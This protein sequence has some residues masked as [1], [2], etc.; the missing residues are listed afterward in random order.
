MDGVMEG[1]H[2]DSRGQ[3]E[4]ISVV[5]LMG[6]T[7]AGMVTVVA[8]GSVALNENQRFSEVQGTDHA[9][10]QLDSRAAVV[11]LGES[12][13]QEV[14]LGRTGGSY[15][16]HEDAGRLI[17]THTNQSQQQPPDNETIYNRSLGAIVY[18][19]AETEVA[20]QGGGVWRKRGNGSTMVSPPEFHYQSAT[21][22]FPI[23]RVRGTGSQAGSVVAQITRPDDMRR[24]YP[25]TSS[26][27]DASGDTYQNPVEG[28]NVT[29]TIQSEYYRAWEN[30]FKSRT[31]G[32]V[33]V[34]H[35]NETVKVT[36]LS[37]SFIGEFE[38]PADGNS[39]DIDGLDGNDHSIENF[40]ITIY[41][42]DTDSADFAD[43]QWSLYDDQGNEEIE[44]HLQDGGSNDNG[45]TACT[46]R[47]V[48]ATVY[49]SDTNGDP[50][51]GW[52]NDTA[53]R[54]ECYDRD[55]DG[56]DDETRLVANFTGDTP[57]TTQ[58]LSSSDLLHFNPSGD[59]RE[60]PASWDQHSA[61]VSWEPE[62]FSNPEDTTIRNITG[63]YM[64]LMGP[65]VSLTVED[66][67]G[68]TVNE[69]ASGGTLEFE[70]S[71]QFVTFLHVTENDIRVKL[72]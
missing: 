3:A 41:P 22:T 1:F 4:T 15:S 14:N 25:N 26:T 59:T 28:G 72:E 61:G 20:Y 53:F 51:H 48:E 11:A 19:N 2:A 13:S 45:S 30:Y 54:T 40:T 46:E 16:I 43:L 29:V 8:L 38:M 7:V 42:D 64:A 67:S 6:I 10:T 5:L 44:F 68:G 60:D 47:D 52:H 71:G 56:T 36:L 37:S 34:F 12:E 65:R 17:I 70:S 9:M 23:I 21:L 58:D 31:E 33:T 39:I 49:Y 69:D 35:N 50:Y 66:K 18:T 24:I 32:V 57:L 27:Y 55:D 63:H 62:D